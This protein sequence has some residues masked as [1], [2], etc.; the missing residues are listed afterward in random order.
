[1]KQYNALPSL[2]AFIDPYATPTV[3]QNDIIID[4]PTREKLKQYGF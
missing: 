2:P 3:D 4:A 1:M